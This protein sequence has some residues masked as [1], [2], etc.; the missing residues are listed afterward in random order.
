MFDMQCFIYFIQYIYMFIYVIYFIN[1]KI[2]T[3]KNSLFLPAELV[4]TYSMFPVKE[5]M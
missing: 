3:V 1:T 2:I 5:R 4:Y